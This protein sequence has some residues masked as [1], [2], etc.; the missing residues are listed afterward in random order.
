M[1]EDLGPGAIDE[2]R[3]LQDPVLELVGFLNFMRASGAIV[4]QSS[5]L[6]GAQ[7]LV[8]ANAVF[9]APEFTATELVLAVNSLQ[10]LP[11]HNNRLL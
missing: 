2:G 11:S 3:L 8:Q 6:R 1:F 5:L 10:V 7:E 9:L 4:D